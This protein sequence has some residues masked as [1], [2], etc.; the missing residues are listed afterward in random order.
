MNSQLHFCYECRHRRKVNG[1]PNGEFRCEIFPKIKIFNTTEATQ[2]VESGD[3]DEIKV[4][5]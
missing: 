3:Y 2:C 4:E 1:L 5:I